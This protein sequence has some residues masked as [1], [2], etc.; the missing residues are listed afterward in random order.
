M[1][2]LIHWLSVVQQY[3]LFFSGNYQTSSAQGITLAQ[4]S[5]VSQAGNWAYTFITIC[6]FLFAFSSI[7]GDY[8][9]WELNIAFLSEKKSVLLFYRFGVVSM[10]IFGAL[11]MR[12]YC[13]GSGG[14]IN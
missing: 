6:I 3:L 10:V 4:H 8:Y 9:Y 13:V 12:T 1:Y 7:I 5:L 14:L 2:L 11:A